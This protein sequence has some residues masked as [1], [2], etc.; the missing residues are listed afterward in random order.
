MTGKNNQKELVVIGA[1][2]GGYTGAFLAADLGLRVTLIDPESNPGGVCLYRGCIPSKALLHLAKIITDAAEAKNFGVEFSRPKIDVDK[3]RS[4]KDS[5]VE[6]LTQGLGLLRNQRKIEYIRGIASFL[7]SNTIEVK[8]AAGTTERITFNHAILATGSHPATIP[9]IPEGCPLVMDSTKALELESIP[10]SMLVI[11]GGY[12]GLELGSVYAVLGTKVSVVEMTPGLMPGMDPEL[13]RVLQK[14]LERLFDSIMLNTTV[15]RIEEQK[16][17]VKVTFEGPNAAVEE[18][19]FE[20]VLVCVGRNPNS[21]GLGLEN[22]NV[23]IDDKG[24]VKVDNRRRTDDDS[25]YAVGD[26]TGGL[27]LAHKAAHEAK[28]AAKAIA[29]LDA[30]FEPRAIPFV[31]YTDPEIAECGL[32]EKQAQQENRNIKVAKFPWA[33]SGRA[34]TLGQNQ[35]LTKLII[36]ADNERVLGVG[37]VG[38]GAGQLISEGALAVEMAAAVSDLALTIHPHPTLSETIMEAAEVFL[39][40]STHFYRPR[41]T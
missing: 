19:V 21:A 23:Q 12:I 36:D 10:R 8:R 28:V 11:G 33:A 9:N 16:D 4:W 17:G 7:D 31:E 6:K 24:F 22:T 15:A 29:G 41:K 20:K 34:A 26:V 35:G 2:P 3:I 18:Q 30:V 14:R 32:T 40:H 13:V 39:G 27:L 5:V 1:G 25:I 37:I 38:T